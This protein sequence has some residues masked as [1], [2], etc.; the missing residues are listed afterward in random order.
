M[1]Y[2]SRCSRADLN[3]LMQPKTYTAPV[4]SNIIL[5]TAAVGFP[6]AS[7]S[8]NRPLKKSNPPRKANKPNR[9]ATW[10]Q[11]FIP[12]GLLRDKK[13][14]RQIGAPR[15]AG[16]QEVIDCEPEMSETRMPHSNKNAP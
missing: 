14:I 6:N 1:S 4:I 5:E 3:D 7:P 9:T 10:L 16:I 8:L 12:D 2:Y 13:P 11:I 15:K